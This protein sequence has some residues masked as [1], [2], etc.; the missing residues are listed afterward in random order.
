MGFRFCLSC[1]LRRLVGPLTYL[2]IRIPINYTSLNTSE[3]GASSPYPRVILSNSLRLPINYICIYLI[4]DTYPHVTLHLPIPTNGKLIIS[5]SCHHALSCHVSY[6][7]YTLLIRH[8]CVPY[9]VTC[10]HVTCSP[11]RAATSVSA[12]PIQQKHVFI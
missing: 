9:H 6:V 4:W 7:T 5:E 10:H 8:S 1:L 3:G 2:S 12:Q 11:K